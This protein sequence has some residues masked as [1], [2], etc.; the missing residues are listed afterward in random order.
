[1]SKA[2][3]NSTISR[4]LMKKKIKEDKRREEKRREEKRKKRNEDK[5]KKKIKERKGKMISRIT[6]TRYKISGHE[7]QLNLLKYKVLC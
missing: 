7:G 3:P 4:G 5:R 2:R 1:M 6:T